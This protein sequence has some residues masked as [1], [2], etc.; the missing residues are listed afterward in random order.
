MDTVG[1]CYIAA[2]GLFSVDENGN[3]KLGGYCEGHAQAMLDFARA[4][5]AIVASEHN[6]LGEPVELRIGLHTGECINR[7]QCRFD[8]V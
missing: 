5:L 6:P 1:D 2:S 4:V 3:E 7:N 8:A